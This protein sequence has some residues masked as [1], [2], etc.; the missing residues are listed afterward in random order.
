MTGQADN[1]YN[2]FGKGSPIEEKIALQGM[3]SKEA[4]FKSMVEMSHESFLKR[5][6]RNEKFV[7]GI[8]K[9]GIDLGGIAAD[10]RKDYKEYSQKLQEKQPEVKS[11]KAPPFA[12]PH[13]GVSRVPAEPPIIV[14]RVP[15]F[16][17]GYSTNFNDPPPSSA[18]SYAENHPDIGTAKFGVG[19]SNGSD[20]SVASALVFLGIYFRPPTEE[21]TLLVNSSPAINGE[22][23]DDCVFSEA[24]T[25]GEI[26]FEV[27]VY[28]VY[29]NSFLNAVTTRD[30]LWNDN[31]FNVGIGGQKIDNPGYALGLGPLHVADTHWH[32]IWV[33]SGSRV[34]ASGW[35]TFSGSGAYGNLNM[36]VPYIT[37]VYNPVTPS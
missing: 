29:D 21:G 12:V 6:K 9:S 36:N 34:Q 15:P 2:R 3:R 1:S 5:A 10:F 4:E 33:Y 31:S 30:Y 35:G 17:Y 23:G 16:D 25:A 18:Y 7:E 22:Y 20:A 32:I 13:V 37:V 27:D 26:G 14:T 19:T 28:D 11:V 8:K 24:T